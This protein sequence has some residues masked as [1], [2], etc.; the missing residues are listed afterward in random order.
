MKRAAQKMLL[1][2]SFIKIRDEIETLVS[3]KDANKLQKKLDEL[4]KKFGPAY[5]TQANVGGSIELNYIFK[6]ENGT[7][8]LN[9][10][11]DLH[12]GLNALL[13][14]NVSAE[15]QYMNGMNTHIQSSIFQSR[16]KGGTIKAVAM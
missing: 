2:S 6:E 4:N 1:S 10:H 9:I 13:S 8:T 14:L 11:G 3:Q 5:I 12:F 7:D 15:A 16:V